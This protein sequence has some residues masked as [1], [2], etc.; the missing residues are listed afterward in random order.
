MINFIKYAKNA[1]LWCTLIGASCFMEAKV[2]IWDLGYTLLEPSNMACAHEIGIGDALAYM[3]SNWDGKNELKRKMFDILTRAGGTQQ[4][5]SP[6]ALVRDYEG[7]AM[8]LMCCRFFAGELSGEEVLAQVLPIINDLDRKCYFS[9]NRE[10]RLVTNA[11]RLMFTPTVFAYSF[12]PIDK[13]TKLLKECA[14]SRDAQ[15]K[16]NIMMIGSNWDSVSFKL[17]YPDTTFDDIFNYIDEKN[18]VLS[19]DIHINKPH[20]EF[21]EYILKTYN[22]SPSDC[23]FID[24]QL[25]NIKAARAVGMTGLHIHKKDYKSIKHEL[26][27]LGVL[28]S[29]RKNK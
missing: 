23:I 18:I 28:P 3:I 17:M 24:D 5:Q 22:L 9:S 4:E 12:K 26:I 1:F 11:L 6:E 10:K 2:V 25:E 21:F 29:K 15:G 7:Q 20:K 27:K 13:A 8:P 19:G 14:V 16:E